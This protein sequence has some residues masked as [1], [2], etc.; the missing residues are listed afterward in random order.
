MCILKINACKGLSLIS[1][2]DCSCVLYYMA[3]CVYVGCM[4]LH[5]C[6]R[7]HVYMSVLN[8]YMYM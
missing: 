2:N 8:V 1:S 6:M 4:C 5:V 3:L 7:M